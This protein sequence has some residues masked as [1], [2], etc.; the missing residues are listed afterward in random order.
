MSFDITDNAAQ[1]YRQI[2]TERRYL[3]RLAIVPALVKF[4]CV[5][6][7]NALGVERAFLVQGLIM[8]PS[9]FT[10][11]WMLAHLTRLT[12]L[13]QRWPFRPSGDAVADEVILHDRFRGVMGGM[14]AYTLASFLL[15]GV[16]HVFMGLQPPEPGM[17]AHADEVNV[18]DFLLSL[19]LMVGMFWSFRLFWSY[20]P[21]ALNYP[22]ASYWQ[23]V[24]GTRTNFRLIGTWLICCLPIL[25]VFSLAATWVQILAGGGE[26]GAVVVFVLALGGVAAE[27]ASLMVA[28]VGIG[29]AIRAL[30]MPE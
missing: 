3:V 13:G 1:A 29:L 5:I 27:L 25:F 6:V 12:F 19:A 14:V 21:A 24:R 23:A 26:A 15:S 10:E 2:W 7:V 22:L 16:M 20:I 9:F 28:T 17:P 18:P 11:G 8:L 4:V 30:M